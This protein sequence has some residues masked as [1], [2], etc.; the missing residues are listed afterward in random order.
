MKIAVTGTIGSGKSTLCK[1]LAALLPGFDIV[2][3]D[4]VVRSIYDDADF[5]LTLASQFGVSTRQEASNLVFGN[6]TARRALEQLSFQFIVPKLDA[7][8][9]VPNAIVEFPLLFE[10]SDFATHQANLVVAVGCSDEVQRER[11]IAR[12]KMPLEKLRAVRSSQYSRELRE[13][14]C[15]VYVDTGLSVQEQDAA[16]ERILARVRVH[17]LKERVAALVGLD[18]AWTAVWDALETRYSE[19]HRHYHTLDHLHELFTALDVHMKDHPYAPAMQLA[20]LFHDLVYETSPGSYSSNEAFSAK[21]MLH[22]LAK[23]IPTWLQRQHPMHE[24]VYLAAEIIVA[25]KTHKMHADWVKAK[26]MLLHAAQLFLDADMSILAASPQRLQEYDAQIAGEWGQP[27]GRE[28]F[29]FCAGRLRALD[30]FS[31][32]NIFLTPEFAELEAT[33]QSNIALLATH[34][35]KRVATFNR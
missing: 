25:T 27:I 26:P 11:V 8:L 2:S 28:N 30:A 12:D 34:W 21:Q 24:Q 35:R 17:Q 32:T 6:E 22:I 4:D 23:H 16:C 18:N 7:A 3:V 13:A 33:A 31:A 9:A 29:Q 15:D 1:K 10:M 14:L 19:E 5:L 20:V